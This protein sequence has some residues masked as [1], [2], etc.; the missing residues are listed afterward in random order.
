MVVEHSDSVR[1]KTR[2]LREYVSSRVFKAQPAADEPS[3]CHNY[4]PPRGGAAA[5]APAVAANNRLGIE[6]ATPRIERDGSE[7]SGGGGG[8][9]HDNNASSAAL[10]KVIIARCTRLCVCVQCA[11]CCTVTPPCVVLYIRKHT[12]LHHLPQLCTP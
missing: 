4:E 12:L 8:G 6:R 5:R 11:V 7:S 2:Q 10:I 1:S 3:S 9:A